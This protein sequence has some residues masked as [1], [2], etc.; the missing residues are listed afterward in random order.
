MDIFFYDSNIKECLSKKDEIEKELN[1]IFTESEINRY[2]DVD[3]MG[4]YSGK[5]R[6][7]QTQY[8]LSKNGGTVSIDC[9]DWSEELKTKEGYTDNLSITVYSKEYENFIRYEAY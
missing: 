9:N 8:L 6:Q 3:H 4:D 1:N 7:W 2:D 5:S